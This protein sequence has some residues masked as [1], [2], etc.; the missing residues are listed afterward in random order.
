M[1]FILRLG[2][3]KVASVTVSVSKV[4]AQII[5]GRGVHTLKKHFATGITGITWL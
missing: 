3:V 1:K 2:E 4:H 5:K